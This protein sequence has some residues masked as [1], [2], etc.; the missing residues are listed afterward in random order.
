[1]GYRIKIKVNNDEI[2]YQVYNLLYLRP[3]YS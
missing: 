2:S 1:M 3:A